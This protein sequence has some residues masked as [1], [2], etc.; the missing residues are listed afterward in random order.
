MEDTDNKN[1]QKDGR[2]N[3][4]RKNRQNKLQENDL[5]LNESIT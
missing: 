1:R 2:N 5:L 3:I 4:V